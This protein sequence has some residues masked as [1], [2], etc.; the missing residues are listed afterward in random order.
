MLRPGFLKVLVEWT[1]GFLRMHPRSFKS[2]TERFELQKLLSGGAKQSSADEMFA[3]WATFD[4][5][6]SI[7]DRK[8]ALDYFVA[9]NPLDLPETDMSAYADLRSFHV[10]MFDVVRC[11]PL[12]GV[13]L[14]SVHGDRFFV[15]DIKASM[16]LTRGDAIWARVGAISD[17]Y[18]MIGAM[19]FILP[20]SIIPNLRKILIKH[21]QTTFDAFLIAHTALPHKGQQANIHHA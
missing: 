19:F 14:V 2:A 10:G 13:E 7:F 21:D 18:Y 6:L 5:R 17:T 9:N 20:P 11:E 1:M 16:S 15:H 4:A 3:E 12:K 8:T